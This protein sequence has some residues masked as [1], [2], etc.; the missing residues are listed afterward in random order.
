MARM[1]EKHRQTSRAMQI[2]NN[3]MDPEDPAV[4]LRRNHILHAAALTLQ[5]VFR[6]RQAR[7][8]VAR[9]RGMR[10]VARNYGTRLQQ[11]EVAT[12][13]SKAGLVL[14]SKLAHRAEFGDMPLARDR[15]RPG[16]GFG[17]KPLGSSFF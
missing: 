5:R 6:G 13:N 11:W 8:L 7:K 12:L 4:Q 16:A 9:I 15:G 10:Q 1:Y 2:Y 17:R 14:H 3:H